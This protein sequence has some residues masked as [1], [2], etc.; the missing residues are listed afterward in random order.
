M[1]DEEATRRL[2]DTLSSI[3]SP[4]IAHFTIGGRVSQVK[5]SETSINPAMR[6]SLFIIEPVVEWPS[7]APKDMVERTMR[8]LTDV[9]KKIGRVSGFSSDREASYMM[10]SDPNEK[11][12]QRVDF[13]KQNYDKL[14]NIK[15]KYDKEG[16]FSCYR[17]VGS[18]YFGH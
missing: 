7:M 15:K 11:D 17:C 16:T 8:Y 12:W 13:G 14:M 5:P 4:L 18:D 9:T 3:S 10:E 2:A 1:E 6:E